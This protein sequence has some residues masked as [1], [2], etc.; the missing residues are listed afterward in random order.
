MKY[1][2]ILL[3]SFFISND[4]H[5]QDLKFS[6]LDKSPLDVVMYRDADQ[7]AIARVIYSRPSKRDRTVFGELVPYEQV[8]RTGANEAT[9]ITFYKD[10]IIADETVAAGTYSIYTVPNEDEWTFILNTDTTQ[11]GTNYNEENNVLKAPM[12]VTPAP[13]SIESFSITIVD[14]FDGGTMFM[15]W[16]NRIA[17]LNFKVVQP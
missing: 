8:W 13:E 15:G 17:S 14:D 11:W 12:N 3:A 2:L 6:D 4:L 16:D 1:I 7:S 10:V 5:S 9:E